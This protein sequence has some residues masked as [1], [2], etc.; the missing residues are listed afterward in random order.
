[1]I[2]RP[3]RSTQPTTL[4]PY[5]T[6]FR[7][8]AL[9]KEALIGYA[10]ADTN[11]PGNLPCPDVDNDGQLTMNVDFIG[12]NCTSPIG[13]LPW[14][15]LGLTDLRDGAGEHLW[16]AVARTFWSTR[17]DPINSDT[18]GDLIITGTTA[19][20]NAIAILF[21]PGDT[22]PVSQNRSTTQ[23]T[24]VT[25]GTTLANNLCASN[26]LEGSNANI[27]LPATPNTNYQAALASTTF[28]DQ[29]MPITHETLFDNV[30]KA[31]AR[32]FKNLAAKAYYDYWGMYPFASTLNA[33]SGLLPV[34]GTAPIPHWSNVSGTG[35]GTYNCELRP[36]GCSTTS[37]I[38]VRCN[39]GGL[40]QGDLVKVNGKIN[41]VGMGFWRPYDPTQGTG[42]TA[43]C[44]QEVCVRLES[45]NKFYPASSVLNNVQITY[46]GIDTAGST[47]IT[48]R[49]N[50][51]TGAAN[52]PDR[53]EF[54]TGGMPDYSP[55]WLI[56]N[57][58][59]QVMY[60]A[61]SAGFS[62]GGGN[63]CIPLPATPSCLTVN[64]NGGVNNIRAAI[65]MTGNTLPGQS[66]HPSGNVADYLEGENAS[67][68]DLTYENQPR[69]STFND[70][71][72][73]VAP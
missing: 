67:P 63:T 23:A 66:P 15:T 20:N 57:N 37:C 53:I 71:I 31:V 9:A 43:S 61:A 65:M 68:A 24:C 7:S 36:A 35:D 29:V 58:W 70:Q 28:N 6:L 56:A 59:P 46:G 51:K 22:L 2:R 3:P 69:S 45:D 33:A 18:A 34:A 12:N 32:Q 49:G 60:Y 44:T 25:T 39:L 64:G 16:Y 55:S 54:N 48:F 27:N 38:R 41:M 14:K 13:R 47:T 62:P 42:G 11:R 21:A 8:L 30:E 17:N 4:F 5:T 50:V 26:Y 72:I 52:I 1:M 40:A 19:L 10:A 73:V